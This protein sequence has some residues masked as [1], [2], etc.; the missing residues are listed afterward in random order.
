MKKYKSKSCRDFFNIFLMGGAN[1]RHSRAI[2]VVLGR[3][4]NDI[5]LLWLGIG[6]IVER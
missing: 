5:G 3:Y 2:L 1:W 4:W 6:T